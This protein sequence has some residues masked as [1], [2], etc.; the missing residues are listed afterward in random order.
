MA[1]RFKITNDGIDDFTPWYQED[2]PASAPLIVAKL[3]KANPDGVLSVERQEID[4]ALPLDP[5]AINTMLNKMR[6]DA[7]WQPDEIA[8]GH[9]F[10]DDPNEV[11]EICRQKHVKPE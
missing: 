10:P 6:V 8:A 5:T 11:C 7:G 1:F 9:K 2:S 4:G 3:R